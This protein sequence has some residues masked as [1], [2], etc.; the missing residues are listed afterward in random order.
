MYIMVTYII[1]VTAIYA[2]YLFVCLERIEL[3]FVW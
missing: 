1:C 2:L 3:I